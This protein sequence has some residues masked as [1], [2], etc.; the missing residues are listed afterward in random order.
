MSYQKELVSRT[1]ESNKMRKTHTY[2]SLAEL[3]N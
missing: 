3:G 2:L 1:L